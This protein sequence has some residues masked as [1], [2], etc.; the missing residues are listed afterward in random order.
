MKFDTD[1]L[2]VNFIKPMT[3][4]YY[5]E[6]RKYTL[7]HSDTTGVLFLDIADFYNYDVVNFKLRDEVL[8]EWIKSNKSSY[9]LYLYVYLKGVD[10]PEISNKYKIFKDNLKLAITGILYGDIELFKKHPDLLDSPIHIKFSSSHFMFNSV[11]YYETPKYYISKY[12]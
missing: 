8:G 12:I 2:K 11:E 10:A 4:T 7:T 5:I 3:P 1:K 6:N 9:I